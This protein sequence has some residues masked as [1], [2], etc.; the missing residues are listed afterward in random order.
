MKCQYCR[1]DPITKTVQSTAGSATMDLCD[2]CFSVFIKG[3]WIDVTWIDVTIKPVVTGVYGYRSQ[4][5]TS[6]T[7]CSCSLSNPGP[8][9]YKHNFFG[10]IDS[11][12][13]KCCHHYNNSSWTDVTPVAAKYYAFPSAAS[14]AFN[15]VPIVVNIGS[16]DSGD[17]GDTIEDRVRAELSAYPH[18]K[19]ECG[20]HATGSNQHSSW[21]QLA[22]SESA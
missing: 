9:K 4:P 7:S 22:K 3:S 8:K 5:S 19:C 18:I 1:K 6:I 2:T 11:A 20:A 12:C 10:I 14:A 16:G 15:G 13:D 21:C 17:S